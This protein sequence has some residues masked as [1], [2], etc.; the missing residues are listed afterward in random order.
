[1]Q[2]KIV[3]SPGREKGTPR[4][5]FNQIRNANTKGCKQP[6]RPNRNGSYEKP[7]K[8]K[9]TKNYNHQSK[10]KIFCQHSRIEYK[11]RRT[12]AFGRFQCCKRWQLHATVSRWQR[13]QLSGH[14]Q[15]TGTPPAAESDQRVSMSVCDVLACMYV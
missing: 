2:T 5:Y 4:A 14:M 1:M 3:A 12:V 8:Q 13:Q 11:F 9:G 10:A 6:E 7:V 15:R